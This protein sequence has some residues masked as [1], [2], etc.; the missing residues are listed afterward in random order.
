M[1]RYSRLR[2]TIA[3]ELFFDYARARNSPA[4]L[5]YASADKPTNKFDWKL[6]EYFWAAAL[7]SKA[8]D[9]LIAGLSDEAGTDAPAKQ[10]FVRGLAKRRVSL[11]VHLHL[12]YLDQ[13][14]FMVE[15]LKSTSGFDRDV[16][17]TTCVEEGEFAHV[18]REAVGEVRVLRCPNIGYDV[19]PFL[20][21]LKSVDLSKY[22]YVLKIHTKNARTADRGQVFGQD[23]LGY[24]WRDDL[25]LALLDTPETFR[26]NVDILENDRSIGCLAHGDYI[27][28]T[29]D[30]NEEVSY[31]LAYWRELLGIPSGS[32]YVGGTM[33]LARAFPF[34]KFAKLD[35]RDADFE[36]GDN[37]TG[38]HR[39]LAHVFER[40]FGVVIGN[41]GLTF[42]SPLER[43]GGYRE[44]SGGMADAAAPETENR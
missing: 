14:D 20:R 4:I 26:A 28:S 29:T 31:G 15:A 38:S 37:A 44:Y 2:G 36:G 21:T 8:A 7:R 33:F 16:V 10:A 23:V 41:E 22:D 35:L 27:F 9:K 5:H 18:I 11:L 1:Q 25:I 42:S 3:E 43:P 40:L 6:G 24:K 17:V 30:R 32:A 34:E 19:Y 13:L 39:N 12:Y